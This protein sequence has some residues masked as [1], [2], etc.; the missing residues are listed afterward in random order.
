MPKEPRTR[1]ARHDS[2]S[3]RAAS[4]PSWD[5]TRTLLIQSES[6][7]SRSSDNALLLREFA[8]FVV[9]PNV[10]RNDDTEGL[11]ILGQES[12]E[13]MRQYGVSMGSAFAREMLREG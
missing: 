2:S 4:C 1:E 9:G 3:H 6:P 11:R 8:S 12:S 7:K 10:D 13:R 5:R